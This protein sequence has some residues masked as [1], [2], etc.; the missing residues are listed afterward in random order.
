MVVLLSQ[1]VALRVV[2]SVL[3]L[4]AIAVPAHAGRVAVVVTDPFPLDRYA[5]TG[6]VGLLVPGAGST[7][8][9][10]GALAA[11]VRGQVKSALLGGTPHGKVL[12]RVATRPAPVTIYVSL[13]PPGPSHNVRRYPIA[14]VGGGYRG[15]LVS[16][17]TRVDGLVSIADVAPTA[18]ALAAGDRPRI[19]SHAGGVAAL[20][21]LDRRLTEAH[22]ARTLAR[23]LVALA[24]LALFAA[25]V[26]L[27]SRRIA[28]AG[29]LFAPV[30]LA[31]VLALSALQ[32][33]RLAVVL[34]VLAA[35]G[36]IA[37]LLARLGDRFLAGA[38][39]CF[40]VAY[41]AL[42]AARPEL[43]SLAVLGPHPDGGGRYY[44]VT[45]EVE[46][47]LLAPMLA[48][49][50]VLGPVA[51]LPALLLVAWSRAG[52]DGGG[53]LVFAAA[54][55]V[56]GL[57]RSGRRLSARVVLLGAVAVVLVAL[58]VVLV[59]AATG[60]SSHVVDA[61]RS[62]P[63][64][65]AEEAAHRWRVSWAGATSSGAVVAQSLGGLAALAF[66]GLLRPRVPV[67]DA[68]LVAVAV[69]LVV[70]DTPQDVLSFGALACGSLLVWARL[71]PA[72]RRRETY[73]FQPR[74]RSA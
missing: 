8:T 2:L 63:S 5:A 43:N 6:A 45:N 58:L 51:A 1:A 50:A 4:L 19:E 13:P 16:P 25:A 12:I 44:G 24:L 67:V 30:V 27:R 23:G 14:I 33:A 69:S 72:R 53:L 71:A 21:S 47:L 38:V 73:V 29:V 70:N 41:V 40:L 9:R 7:V 57:R 11:L 32:E 74:P 3:V 18:V 65:W 56:L 10:E 17:A 52:A 66:F 54:L 26:L 20:R 28:R 48:A 31:A 55:G 39:V 64:G 49:A 60:G 35:C 42:L 15:V 46:T 37:L 68:F 36:A 61:V 62:G 34:P 22:D 59:D